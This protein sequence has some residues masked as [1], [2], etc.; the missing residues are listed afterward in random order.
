MQ[1]KGI[2]FI[3]AKRELANDTL[4]RRIVATYDYLDE[5]GAPLYQ[6]RRMSGEPKKFEAWRSDGNGGWIP[7]VKEVRRVLYRLPEVIASQQICIPEGEK[8]ADD[9]HSLGFT[10]TTNPFGAGKWR[11]EYNEWLK[12]KDVLIFG[13]VGDKN[14][15][16]EKH[17][18]HR[19]RSLTG[20]A[21]S[22]KH[23]QL[24]NG[25][26]DISDYIASLSKESAAHIIWKLIQDTPCI[27]QNEQHN[28]SLPVL[29]DTSEFFTREPSPLPPLII[30]HILHQGS[31]MLPPRWGAR[32]IPPGAR[33][34]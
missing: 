12:D 8:N 3:E 22:I 9:L 34:R 20:I 13:D 1:E 7:G 4:P 19:I 16:G 11:D 25:F 2:P 28:Y 24:P 26:H 14:G 31:K 17:T 6:V 29:L 30:H 21:R 27:S 5:A 15:D 33:S 10:A 18:A 32:D 23:V